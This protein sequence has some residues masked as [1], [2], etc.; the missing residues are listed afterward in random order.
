M[1][2]GEPLVTILSS[3]KNSGHQQVTAPK[4][5]FLNEAKP[6]TISTEEDSTKSSPKRLIPSPDESPIQNENSSEDKDLIMSPD[7]AQA[8]DDVEQLP[9]T[10]F[11]QDQTISGSKSTCIF[12]LH[13]PAMSL[14]KHST[15][16]TRT[17]P[18]YIEQLINPGIKTALNKRIYKIIE[19][20]SDKLGSEPSITQEIQHISN[21][22]QNFF[23]PFHM[24]DTS[25]YPISFEDLSNVLNDHKDPVNPL[26]VNVMLD[27]RPSRLFGTIIRS[28][29][30]EL[31]T[32]RSTTSSRKSHSRTKKSPG[33]EVHVPAPVAHDDEFDELTHNLAKD[34]PQPKDMDS[35][36]NN[37]DPAW[38]SYTRD[39]F[40]YQGGRNHVLGQRSQ[41]PDSNNSKAP[42]SYNSKAPGSSNSKSHR[43]NPEDPSEPSE[44][45]SDFSGNANN[46][47]DYPEGPHWTHYVINPFKDIIADPH[48]GG[49][50]PWYAIKHELGRTLNFPLNLGNLQ[51]DKDLFLAQFFD[52]RY[53][54][55]AHFKSFMNRFPQFPEDDGP[56]FWHHIIPF[57]YQVTQH[58]VAFSI[59]VPPPHTLRP[60]DKLGAWYPELPI[61]TQRQI[62]STFNNIL[63]QALRQKQTHLVSHKRLSPFVRT[64]KQGYDMIMSL[65][66]EAGH[67][68]L[69]QFPET[70]K[71][72]RQNSD[73]SII[74]YIDNWSQY[75][76]RMVLT[77]HH[78]N[79]R[80]FY[81]Q[82]FRNSHSTFKP[83]FNELRLAVHE[84]NHRR[85]LPPSFQMSSLLTKI[86]QLAHF[87]DSRVDVTVGSRELQK[88]YKPSFTPL[89][90]AQ[91]SQPSVTSTQREMTCYMCGENHP[92][93]KCPMIQ[94]ILS[95]DKGKTT[96]KRILDTQQ[97]LLRQVCEASHDEPD[98]HQETPD[99]LEDEQEYETP[100]EAEEDQDFPKAG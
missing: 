5:L 30:R 59:Y 42:G 48:T 95:N 84:Q 14:L 22:S 87:I 18:I 99:T 64:P 83:I 98:S 68:S 78:Y 82:L 89:K 36:A 49:I 71:E 24:T 12:K 4:L 2:D 77:G 21:S 88:T 63:A 35:T 66:I 74:K 26:E 19:R 73:M 96:L 79:D 3:P 13:H 60:G 34:Q 39:N 58:C 45:P 52:T 56:G 76:Q 100:D 32:L 8:F 65:A 51:I 62:P 1:S 6:T 90:V 10:S 11:L 69:Q 70:P 97:L 92:L 29:V 20:I 27:S 33:A 17:C 44:D 53:D 47:D 16:V 91:I 40:S 80:F 61:L 37:T 72:P 9:G 55:H 38:D 85:P 7:L 15:Y 31:S 67:P 28:G 86:T 41:M 81:Q 23:E 94:R 43:N 75:L 50:C 46:H 25:I 57:L 93:Y 54:P